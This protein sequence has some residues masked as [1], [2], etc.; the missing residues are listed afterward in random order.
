M[1]LRELFKLDFTILVVDEAQDMTPLYFKLL[2]KFIQDSQLPFQLL[3]LGDHRQGLYEFKGADTRFLTLAH[4]LWKNVPLKTQSF[5][6]KSLKCLTVLPNRFVTLLIML[7]L[8]RNICTLVKMVRRFII[9]NEIVTNLSLL[10]VTIYFLLLN[11][12]RDQMI[13][14][15]YVAL[16]AAVV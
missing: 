7:C 3:V 9:L 13:S 12:V 5:I 14:S 11:K 16:F 6:H 8:E 4:K 1:P 15:F 10:F 2:Q